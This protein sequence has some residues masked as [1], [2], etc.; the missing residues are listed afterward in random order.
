MKV[1]RQILAN[2]LS[3]G[4]LKATDA[5]VLI[6]LIPYIVG[7]VGIVNYGMLAFVTVFLNAG[8][9]LV[10]YGFQISGVRS[11][12]LAREQRGQLSAL[13]WNILYARL[14]LCLVFILVIGI[15]IQCIPYLK[16]REWVFYPGFLL[17]FGHV[18]FAD[19]FFIAVQKAK[20][21][22]WA[23]LGV[24][25]MYAALVLV[26]IRKPEDFILI[27]ALQGLAGLA[28]GGWILFAAIRQYRLTWT[29]PDRGSILGFIRSDFRL[30]LSNLSV[31][32]NSSYSILMLNI[33]TTDSLTGYFQVMNKLA[34]PLRFLL[35]IFSQA[36]FPVVCRKAEEGWSAVVLFLKRAYL[37][38][39][40]PALGAILL[41]ALFAQPLLSVFAGRSD[42]FLVDNFRLYLLVPV[43]VLLNIPATQLL[44][45][46]ERKTA[47]TAVFLSAMAVKT[48][49]DYLMIRYWGLRGLV[50]SCL[51]V[52]AWI[53]AGLWFASVGRR[54]V[55]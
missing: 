10:D 19:W 54:R 17:P 12:A 53:L 13:F 51:I 4:L 31:E 5:I 34:Q 22:A 21:I 27:P 3:L 42:A 2:F 16:A 44:L 1:W 25:L 15:A 35:V 39:C 11:V 41:T 32:F 30:F 8:K 14:A 7:K 24:K 43:L 46:Y 18:L 47:Y 37:F 23:N 52:E 9:T 36:I 49:S 33:L 45:A 38:F 29:P 20:V 55:G 50:L 28:A 40:G 48:L 26:I 6:L